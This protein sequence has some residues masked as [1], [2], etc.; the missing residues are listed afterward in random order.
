MPK[1]D[2]HRHPRGLEPPRGRGIDRSLG[3][4]LSELMCAAGDATGFS[5]A[6]RARGSVRRTILEGGTVLDRLRD[7]IPE[8]APGKQKA[9]LV[10]PAPKQSSR[11]VRLRSR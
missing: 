1:T 10:A 7:P 3:P 9:A 4:R 11:E 5:N 2:H 6:S 8:T